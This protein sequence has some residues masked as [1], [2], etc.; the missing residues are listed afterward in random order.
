MS[1]V[2]IFNKNTVCST[3]GL[4]VIFIK[5]KTEG[6]NKNIRWFTFGSATVT[7]TRKYPRYKPNARQRLTKIIFRS[8]R[9][10]EL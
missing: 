7:G 1:G 5:K 3:R 4:K 9:Y 8:S 2:G 10:R 6:L